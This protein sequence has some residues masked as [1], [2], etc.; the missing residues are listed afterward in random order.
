[1]SPGALGPVSS[2]AT[3]TSVVFDSSTAGVGAGEQALSVNAATMMRVDVFQSEV[4]VVP[5]VATQ[6]AG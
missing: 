3:G 6:H 4:T 2:G 5:F 1:V